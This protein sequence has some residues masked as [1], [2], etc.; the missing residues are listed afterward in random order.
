[1]GVVVGDDLG[2]HAAVGIGLAFAE[3]FRE[4]ERIRPRIAAKG[5]AHF[6]ST[7]HAVAAERRDRI[8]GGRTFEQTTR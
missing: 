7:A 5:F 8:S 6:A 2:R 3:N 4:L 1:L